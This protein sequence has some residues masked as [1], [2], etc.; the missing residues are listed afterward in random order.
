MVRGKSHGDSPKNVSYRL[1]RR[2]RL[3]G[4]LVRSVACCSLFACCSVVL[5][6][7][8]LRVL[9]LR[10]LRDCVCGRCRATCVSILDHLQVL[11]DDL[12]PLV[13]GLETTS[14]A[15]A[16]GRCKLWNCPKPYKETRFPNV[17]DTC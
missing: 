14:A 15:T 16:S 9:L 11:L 6:A 2:I 10:V 13:H 4:L 3:S 8:L 7:L 17:S 12:L 5:R 1:P